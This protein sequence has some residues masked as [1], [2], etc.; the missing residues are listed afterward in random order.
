MCRKTIIFVLALTMCSLSVSPA[1]ELETVFSDTMYQLTGVAI[2]KSGRLFVTY[3]R[4]LPEHR[5]DVVEVLKNGR[6]VPFP[7]EHWNAWKQGDDGKA[8]FVCAQAVFVDALDRLWVVDPASPALA[9]VVPGANKL[10]EIDLTTNTVKRVYGFEHAVAGKKSY[11]NDVRVDTKRNIAYLTE[12][13]GGAIIVLDLK[14]GKARRRLGGSPSAKS[15]PAYTFRIAGKELRN[16]KG[17][18]KINA[19]GIALTPDG[20]Y[21][22]YKPLTDAKLYRI[23]TRHLLDNLLGRAALAEKVEVVGDITTTDGMIFDKEGRLY[24]GDLEK[25]AIMRMSPEEKMKL[26]IRDNRLGWPDSYAIS[27]DGFLY[28]TDSQIQAMPWFN[29]GQSTRTGPYTVYRLKVQ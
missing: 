7:D 24:F 4:W 21:L 5:Y 8:M 26:L 22:Y 6:T 13:Q 20:Q 3:P 19:D 15:D 28:I 18:V 23:A 14:T 29:G 25:G 9:G 11:L 1:A 2:S 17:P 10:V 16:G 27:R 12:S